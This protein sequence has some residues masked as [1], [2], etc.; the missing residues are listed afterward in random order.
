VATTSDAGLAQ[1]AWTLGKIAGA[2]Q[3]TVAVPAIAV[4]L[5][6]AATGTP[7]PAASIAFAPASLRL[8]TPIDTGH[9]VARAFDAFGNTTALSPSV[10]ARDP[11]LVTIDTSGQVRVQRRRASTYVVATASGVRDSALVT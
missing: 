10:A 4:P 2:Q 3:L 11:T 8:V 1:T 9:L 6:F 5:R 7:G